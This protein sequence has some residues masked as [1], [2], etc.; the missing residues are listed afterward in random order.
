MIFTETP[1]ASLDRTTKWITE[2]LKQI[3]ID[4]TNYISAILTKR[5]I[6]CNTGAA[7]YWATQFGHIENEATIVSDVTVALTVQERMLGILSERSHVKAV[8]ALK[9]R[10]V[11][12]IR[13]IFDIHK[14]ALETLGSCVL[15]DFDSAKS[16]LLRRGIDLTKPGQGEILLWIY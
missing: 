12:I 7:L 16:E 6:Q 10:G 11:C 14:S 8:D 1:K 15:A 13:G 2:S 3:C 9:N 5:Y 4:S